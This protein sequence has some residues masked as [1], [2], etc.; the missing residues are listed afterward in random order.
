MKLKEMGEKFDTG[1]NPIILTKVE[2]DAYIKEFT[3][4]DKGMELADIW[5]KV[6]DKGTVVEGHKADFSKE[7]EA[8][9]DKVF[10]RGIEVK[11]R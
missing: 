7:I 2:Y 10:F 11:C 3:V 8:N 6:M 4:S 9:K 5:S 1:E